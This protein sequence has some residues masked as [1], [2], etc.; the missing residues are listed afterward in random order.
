[1][2]V[3]SPQEGSP[4]VVMKRNQVWSRM[5]NNLLRCVVCRLLQAPPS[6]LSLFI[7]SQC[8]WNVSLPQHS[9]ECMSPRRLACRSVGPDPG[10]V[11]CAQV[12]SQGRPVTLKGWRDRCVDR[13]HSRAWG[14]AEA[15]YW[16]WMRT[17]R[18]DGSAVGFI[19]LSVQPGELA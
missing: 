2:K 16:T 14:W 7:C 4:L 6:V 8:F 18:S 3:T 12:D 5:P 10:S 15:F 9:V 1:M 13:V 11:Q 19:S 17:K